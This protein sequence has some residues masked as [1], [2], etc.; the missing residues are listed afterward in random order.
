VSTE[1]YT[2]IVFPIPISLLVGLGNWAS[3]QNADKQ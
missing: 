3:R 2:S 1:Q